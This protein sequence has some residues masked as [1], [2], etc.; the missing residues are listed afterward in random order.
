M[1]D[2]V[3]ITAYRSPR[4]CAGRIRYL[5]QLSPGVA[6]VCIYTGPTAKAHTFYRVF[7]ACHHHYILP[8]KNTRDNW[9]NLDQAYARWWLSQGQNLHADRLLF[10]DWDVLLLEPADRLFNQLQPGSAHFCNVFPVQDLRLDHWAREFTAANRLSPVDPAEP[11]LPLSRAI[12]FAWGCCACDFTAVANSVMQLQGYCEMRLAY[13]CRC[14]GLV[15][16]NLQPQPLHYASVSGLGLS[17]RSLRC[18]QSDT[19]QLQ[20]A[21]PV[22]LPIVASNLAIDW[23]AWLLEAPFLKTLNRKIKARLRAFGLRIGL[24]PPLNP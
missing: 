2:L 3:V 12:L 23:P 10:L 16:H 17:R 21:H 5:R 13:A 22:Y 20:L 24:I 18:L 9:G 4:L 1:K 11:A 14:H 7:A 8:T 6:V 19:S 15:L